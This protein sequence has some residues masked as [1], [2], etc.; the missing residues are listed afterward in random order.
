MCRASL[1]GWN[2]ANKSFAPVSKSVR[3]TLPMPPSANRYWRKLKNRMVISD[4][5]IAY[6]QHVTALVAGTVD[7]PYTGDIALIIDVFR[8][9]KMGDLD[10]RLKIIL[11]ALQGTIY[12]DDKQIVEIH[13]IRHEDKLN[14][15]VEVEVRFLSP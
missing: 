5:A 13:A 14:P 12:R 4:E 6:K 10:N 3:L 9:Y 8:R 2:S 7:T 1:P 15:R 11:D